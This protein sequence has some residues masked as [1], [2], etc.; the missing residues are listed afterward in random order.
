[1]I[2]L[3]LLLG[4]LLVL[5]KARTFFLPGLKRFVLMIARIVQSCDVHFCFHYVFLIQ[6]SSIHSFGH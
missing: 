5:W 1:M 6:T 4:L 3:P 2:K